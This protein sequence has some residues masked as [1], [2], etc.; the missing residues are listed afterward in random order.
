MDCKFLHHQKVNKMPAWPRQHKRRFTELSG[1]QPKVNI[2][3]CLSNE[4]YPHVSKCK[5]SAAGFFNTYAF[6]VEVL[7]STG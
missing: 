3:N 5:Q 7:Q 2:C 4:A 6:L 1:Y